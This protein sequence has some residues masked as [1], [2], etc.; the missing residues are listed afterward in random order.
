MKITFF[1]PDET[2]LKP[3]SV[4]GEVPKLGQRVFFH[5]EHLHDNEHYN[6]YSY[7]MVKMIDYSVYVE[8]DYKLATRMA[9]NGEE[10]N[11]YRAEVHL[12]V[13]EKDEA[14]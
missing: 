3:V 8:T 10:P 7:W 4:I 6:D 14:V 2:N 12:I 1:F 5:S 9:I 11:T 13:G